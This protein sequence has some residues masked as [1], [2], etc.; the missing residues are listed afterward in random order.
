MQVRTR[1][2]QNSKIGLRCA[3]LRGYAVLSDTTSATAIRYLGDAVM[4]GSSVTAME[5]QEGTG[6]EDRCHFGIEGD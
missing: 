2:Y 5:S 4:F 6:K 1:L 3:R